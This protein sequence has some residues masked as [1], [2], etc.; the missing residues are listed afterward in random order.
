MAEIFNDENSNLCPPIKTNPILFYNSIGQRCSVI[1]F[2]DQIRGKYRLRWS[3]QDRVNNAH[4]LG[5]C[6]RLFSLSSEIH[7]V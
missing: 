1:E 2:A 6:K 7:V 5:S 3:A 4:I